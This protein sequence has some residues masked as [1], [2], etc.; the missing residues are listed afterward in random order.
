M[1]LDPTQLILLAQGQ[2]Q[3]Q[4]S[5]MEMFVPMILMVVIF[6]FLLIR[7]QQKK[8]KEHTKMVDAL[9]SGASVVTRGGVIGTVQSVK[10]TTVTVRS[11]ESKFEVE[12]HAI[13]RVTSDKSDLTTDNK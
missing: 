13:E 5:P 2:P 3:P 9:K 8:A 10:D 12:K 1:S 4:G 7:P 11:L 6:Y